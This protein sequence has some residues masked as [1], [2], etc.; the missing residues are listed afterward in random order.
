MR[1]SLLAVII[2]TFI[3]M[4]YFVSMSSFAAKADEGIEV[5]MKSDIVVAKVLWVKGVVNALAP[6]NKTRPLAKDSVL[7]LHDT[8]ITDEKS[9]TQIVF[10]DDTLMTFKSNSKFYIEHYEYKGDKSK[11][12][13]FMN[14]VEGG[15]RT[16]TGLIAKQDP[17]SYQVNTPVATIGVRGTEYEVTYAGGQLFM[18]YEAGTPCVS[19]K[20]GST[21]LSQ[22]AKYVTVPSA[23]SAPI[24]VSEKPAALSENIEIVPAKFSSG[25]GGSTGGSSGSNMTPAGGTDVDVSNFCIS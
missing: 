9:Q 7:Y 12:K 5:S 2:T 14:L 22:E 1:V 23:D 13:Y 11:G 17:D 4:G 20:T 16:V 15:F 24:V 25:G 21:C 6:D 18:G 19:T 8:L 10:T 3:S